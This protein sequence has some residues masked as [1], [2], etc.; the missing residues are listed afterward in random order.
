MGRCECLIFI[1]IE[2]YIRITKGEHLLTRL[3]ARILPLSFRHSVG[4]DYLYGPESSD[5]KLINPQTIEKF[6]CFI[7]PENELLCSKEVSHFLLFCPR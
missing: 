6:P 4:T 2:Q 3:Y 7:E 1:G 5:K